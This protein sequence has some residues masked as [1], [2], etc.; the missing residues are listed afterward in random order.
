MPLVGVN[1][2]IV[3]VM[4]V[5]VNVC[6]LVAEPACVVTVTLPVVAPVGTVAVI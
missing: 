4:P 6:A 2:V 3:G 1:D 5:T